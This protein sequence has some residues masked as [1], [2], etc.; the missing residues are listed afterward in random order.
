MSSYYV[1]SQINGVDLVIPP[2]LA[3]I[4]NNVLIYSCLTF[5]LFVSCYLGLSK[6]HTLGSLAAKYD[7]G[8]EFGWQPH[9]MLGI[10]KKNEK[11]R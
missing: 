6:I 2:L 4:L 10:A 1:D 11:Q 5:V 3:N 9:K 7:P 8:P